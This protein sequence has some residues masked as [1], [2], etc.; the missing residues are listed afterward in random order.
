MDA[1]T[2]K[3]ARINQKTD[4]KMKFRF[5]IYK[6]QTEEDKALGLPIEG[7]YIKFKINKV[8]DSTAAMEFTKLAGDSF[9][10]REKLAWMKEILAD[11][12]D[13]TAT[14]DNQ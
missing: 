13:A 5:K 14:S 11:F 7:L 6:E 1:M 10:F 3:N 12:T 8:N 4:K 2:D 9:F